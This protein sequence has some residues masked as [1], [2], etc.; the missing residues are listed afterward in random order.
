MIHGSEEKGICLRCGKGSSSGGTAEFH[1]G[2]SSPVLT[3]L[4]CGFTAAVGEHVW[5]FTEGKEMGRPYDLDDGV[6]LVM[7]S[8]E[9]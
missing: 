6:L 3:C 4:R 1:D 7:N 5:I 9:V 2:I 8:E